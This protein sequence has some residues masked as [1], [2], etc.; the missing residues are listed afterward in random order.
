VEH[1]Y[2]GTPTSGYQAAKNPKPPWPYLLWC[3][4]VHS[5]YIVVFS[6]SYTTQDLEIDNTFCKYACGYGLMLVGSWFFQKKLGS[7][8]NYYF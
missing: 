6:M 3:Y 5:C 7:C 1:L 2:V 8:L 4:V